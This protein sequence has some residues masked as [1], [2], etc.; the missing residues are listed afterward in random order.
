MAADVRRTKPA[1]WSRISNTSWS[2]KLWGS[3]LYGFCVEWDLNSYFAK[4]QFMQTHENAG[5]RKISTNFYRP[6]HFAKRN[7]KAPIMIKPET[8][9]FEY[10]WVITTSLD[11]RWM[12]I[13][14][15]RKQNS[16]RR[17]AGHWCLPF[18]LHPS[19]CLS[20]IVLHSAFLLQPFG[21]LCREE[22]TSNKHRSKWVKT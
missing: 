7:P 2:R 1:P 5:A 20:I 16:F 9:S 6:R 10:F 19:Q 13:K 8:T 22:K 15:Q 14:K 4:A 3:N 11:E 12:R 21:K 18:F 17:W